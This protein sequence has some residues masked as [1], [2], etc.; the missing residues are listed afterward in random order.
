[1]K[2][3][4]EDEPVKRCGFDAESLRSIREL[5]CFGGAYVTPPAR[6][7]GRSETSTL[8][9]KPFVTILS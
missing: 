3:P 1:M 7:S 5:D 8:F 6:F 9:C 2:A 4:F